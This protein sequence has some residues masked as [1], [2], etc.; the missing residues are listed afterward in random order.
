MK[1][2]L[3]F[4]FLTISLTSSCT[5]DETGPKVYENLGEVYIS[6]VK[7]KYF[8]DHW[9]HTYTVSTNPQCVDTVM[10]LQ[11]KRHTKTTDFS[12]G[13]KLKLEFTK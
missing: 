2:L 12:L 8:H 4:L 13:D 1:N 6:S 7:V 3:K 9:L 11:Y 5:I 10:I